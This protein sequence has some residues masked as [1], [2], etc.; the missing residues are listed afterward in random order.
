MGMRSFFSFLLS[1]NR[2][3]YK[4][5]AKKHKCSSF[6]VYRI[7]H[8]KKARYDRDQLIIQALIKKGIVAGIKLA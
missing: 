7:A 3:A 6:H 5:I 4:E 2:P 1:Q 8:G